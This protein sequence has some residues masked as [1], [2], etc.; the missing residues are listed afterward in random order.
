MKREQRTRSE[1]LLLHSTLEFPTVSRD[2]LSFPVDV[3]RLVPQKT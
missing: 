2:A 1:L 3:G